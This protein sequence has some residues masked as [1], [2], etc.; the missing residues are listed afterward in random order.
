MTIG[1]LGKTTQCSVQTIRYYE[2][3]GLLPIPP[4]SG[5]NYRIYGQEHVE[6]LQFIRNC[7]SLDMSHDEIRRLLDFRDSPERQCHEVNTLLDEHVVHVTRRIDQLTMLERELRKLRDR[8][9]AVR[10]ARDCGILRSLAHT[11]AHDAAASADGHRD[12]GRTHR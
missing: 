6:R 11:P 5:G 1:L 7:R 8:C 10:A 3:E 9:R 2:R 4:R 12:L